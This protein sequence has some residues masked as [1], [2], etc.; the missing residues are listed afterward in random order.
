[1][2]RQETGRAGEAAAA[3]FLE[4]AGYRVL[5]RNYRCGRSGEIDLIA[6]DGD[7]LVFVE[8]KTRRSASF[9]T[10]AEA[11]D[12]RK[13]ARLIRLARYYL[14]IAGDHERICR[15]DVVD[16]TTGPRGWECQLIRDAFTE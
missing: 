12:Q 16:V 14:A 2:K 4:E 9:G 8:V 6:V 5:H 1:M 3:A 15:F 10:G 7:T 13:R 11:V